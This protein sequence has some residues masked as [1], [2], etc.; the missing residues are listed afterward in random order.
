[1]RSRSPRSRTGDPADRT[2]DTLIAGTAW[3]WTD[4][5]AGAAKAALTLRPGGRLVLFRNAFRPAREVAEA[6]TA[7]YA[8]VLPDSPIYRQAMAGP[9]SYA[10]LVAE[11]SDGLAQS[12]AFGEPEQWHF[13]WDRHYTR[14]EWLDQVPTF[15]GHGRLPSAELDALLAGLGDAI[16]VMGGSFTMPC[17]ALVLTSVRTS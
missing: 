8:R 11:A 15:G 9:A 5:V 7:V 13:G 12:G 2:F 17:T 14:E 1:M 4:P 3:H 10:G 16:D 6:F